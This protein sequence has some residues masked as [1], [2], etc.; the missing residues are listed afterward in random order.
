LIEDDR[1]MLVFVATASDG[2]TL[3]ID[4]RSFGAATGRSGEQRTAPL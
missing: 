4:D 1:K 2:S 3:E